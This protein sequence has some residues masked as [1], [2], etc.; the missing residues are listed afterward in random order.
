VVKG[1][2]TVKEDRIVRQKSPEINV[3]HN[4]FRPEELY[5]TAYIPATAFCSP[6]IS[7]R[8]RNMFLS[9]DFATG[10]DKEKRDLHP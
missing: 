1:E 10:K 2:K 4:F 7:A 3:P 8:R 9:L 6:L 5:L